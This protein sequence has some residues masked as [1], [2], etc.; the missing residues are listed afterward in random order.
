MKKNAENLNVRRG[1]GGREREMKGGN[2]GGR[3]GERKRERELGK[4]REAN[5]SN[6]DTPLLKTVG[7]YIQAFHFLMFYSLLLWSLFLTVVPQWIPGP[8]QQLPLSSEI[9]QQLPSPQGSIPP[10]QENPKTARDQLS[11]P[12]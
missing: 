2:E 7:R 3:E 4:G 12:R 1:G 10:W 6:I 5:L 9:S 8:F 11:W